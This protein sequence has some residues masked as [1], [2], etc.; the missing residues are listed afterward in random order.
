MNRKIMTFL[1]SHWLLILVICI[2]I[3]LGLI[4]A[5]LIYLHWFGYIVWLPFTGLEDKTLWDVAEL[6][7]L[8]VTLA[9][10]AAIL[11]RRER[12]DDR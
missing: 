9:I 2:L 6:I 1:K 11:D 12:N 8:P 5:R 3:T 7:I 10:I 4:A